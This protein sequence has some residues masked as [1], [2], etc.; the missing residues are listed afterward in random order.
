VFDWVQQPA[1]FAVTQRRRGDET[2][3]SV[4]GELDLH[5]VATLEQ[6]LRQ[7]D[8]GAL[9]LDLT[10]TTFMDSTALGVLLKEATRRPGDLR[11]VVAGEVRR[12]LE[13]TGLD[14]RFRCTDS[15]EEAEGVAR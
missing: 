3:V 11:L 4:R 12:L 7:V 9:V 2:I 5:T 13:I 10:E 1:P 14:R 8:G 15:L 6:E